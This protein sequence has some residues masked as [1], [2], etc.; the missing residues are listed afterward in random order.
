[1]DKKLKFYAISA[2]VD[3]RDLITAE[4]EDKAK[5]LYEKYLILNN[6]HVMSISVFADYNKE[7]TKKYC[8]KTKKKGK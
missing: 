5:E 1:M 7:M 8:L 6:H 4:S 2:L 3:I